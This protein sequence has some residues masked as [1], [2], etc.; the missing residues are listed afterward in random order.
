MTGNGKVRCLAAGGENFFRQSRQRNSGTSSNL[1]RRNPFL[2]RRVPSQYG[3]AWR[4]VSGGSS[5]SGSAIRC[6]ERMA[7]GAIRPLDA[8]AAGIGVTRN[9]KAGLRDLSNRR[10][11]G[12][13]RILLV[14]GGLWAWLWGF[15]QLCRDD[16]FDPI[17]MLFIL[18][19]VKL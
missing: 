7:Y 16:R 12:R 6:G 15:W 3:H 19:K 14:A 17:P 9:G 4:L 2:T 10:G 8:T 5:R 1:L 18:F 13:T 11:D